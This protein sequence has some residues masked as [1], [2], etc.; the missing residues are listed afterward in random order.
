LA[1]RIREILGRGDVD[2]SLLVDFVRPKE[3]TNRE[4][5]M[6]MHPQFAEALKQAGWI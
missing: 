2:L 1:R 4:R 3:V 5:V 6:V